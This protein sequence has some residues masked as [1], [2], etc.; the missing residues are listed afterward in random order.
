MALMF[1][2]SGS[3]PTSLP[4]MKALP[5][6]G[7]MR[8]QMMRTVVVFPA[9]LGP[10]NPKTSPSWTSRSRSATVVTLSKVRPKLRVSMYAAMPLVSWS[11]A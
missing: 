2:E 6:L 1:I 8:Q 4:A 10:R 11:V 3:R 9:P 7:A 5:P